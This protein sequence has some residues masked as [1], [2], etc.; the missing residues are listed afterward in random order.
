MKKVIFTIAFMLLA[1]N[2][3]T[4][5]S[6]EE[7]NDDTETATELQAIELNKDCPPND[8]NCNGIPDDKE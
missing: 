7:I 4:S 2:V 3:V 6:P 1:F 8:R 5:C